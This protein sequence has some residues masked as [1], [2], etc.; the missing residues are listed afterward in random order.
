MIEITY[1]QIV[2]KK[3][4]PEKYFQ[5]TIL[6]SRIISKVTINRVLQNIII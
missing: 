3:Y 2:G 4:P 1:K 5:V 6:K